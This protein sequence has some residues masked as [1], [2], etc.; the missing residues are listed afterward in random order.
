MKKVYAIRTKYGAWNTRIWYSRADKAYLVEV[1]SFNN[2]VTFGVSLVEAKRMAQDLIELLCVVAFDK[3]Q[4]VIDDE[5][6]VFGRG[7]LSRVSG[8]ATLVPA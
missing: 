5:R 1:P 7:K 3:G 8:T 6:S 4:V 2:A